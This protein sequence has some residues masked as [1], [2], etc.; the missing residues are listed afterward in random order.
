MEIFNYFYF[1][2]L[3]A[4]ICIVL[5]IVL[6][7][8]LSMWRLARPF[9]SLGKDTIFIV[10]FVVVPAMIGF[11][12]GTFGPL[13]LTPGANQ[14]PLIGIFFTGPIGAALGLVLF[15]IYL[16]WRIWASNKSLKNDAGKTGAF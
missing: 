1:T 8:I 7:S 14:G 15:L 2:G 5:G 11:V 4:F 10:V 3:A 12:G 9:I 16:A 13:Y 6:L